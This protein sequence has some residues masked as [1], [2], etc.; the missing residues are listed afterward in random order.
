MEVPAP[1][2][3]NGDRFQKHTKETIMEFQEKYDIKHPQ[4][5]FVI[6][7]VQHESHYQHFKKIMALFELSS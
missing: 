5:M 7:M 6:I 4:E 2:Q 1:D 3:R